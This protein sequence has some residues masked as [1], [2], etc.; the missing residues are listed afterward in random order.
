MESP[1]IIYM[2]EVI[3]QNVNTPDF[4]VIADFDLSGGQDIILSTLYKCLY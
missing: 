4:Y 1:K 2:I 3:W